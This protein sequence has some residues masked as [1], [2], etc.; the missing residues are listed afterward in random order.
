LQQEFVLDQAAYYSKPNYSEDTA[1]KDR[2][3]AQQQQIEY[4]QAEIER[5]KDKLAVRR[6]Q[7]K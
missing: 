3:N 1:G 2:L 5:L 4:L 7:I 6:R